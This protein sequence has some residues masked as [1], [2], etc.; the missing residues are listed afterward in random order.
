MFKDQL[1]AVNRNLTELY[2]KPLR[3][4][5]N[6]IE[7]LLSSIKPVVQTIKSGIVN[8]KDAIVF[9]GKINLFKNLIHFILWLLRNL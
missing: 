9:L 3:A 1:E 7:K 2:L 4:L 8:I 5:R 6:G